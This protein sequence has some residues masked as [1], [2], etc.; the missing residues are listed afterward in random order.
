VT[1][2]TRNIYNN[3]ILPRS[4]FEQIPDRTAINLTHPW[5]LAITHTNLAKRLCD[6]GGFQASDD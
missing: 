3:I 5:I 2:K 4:L 1:I 6:S